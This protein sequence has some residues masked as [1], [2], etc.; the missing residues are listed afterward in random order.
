[1]SKVI[2]LNNPIL[3]MMQQVTY[4]Q[5]VAKVYGEN[6]NTA[7]TQSPMKK[8]IIDKKMDFLSYN[9]EKMMDLPR[10]PNFDRTEATTISLWLDRI[11]QTFST[12]EKSEIREVLELLEVLRK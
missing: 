6:A 7:E 12:L 9:L 2:A 11:R 10:I 8:R 5:R 4:S 3:D 1:M